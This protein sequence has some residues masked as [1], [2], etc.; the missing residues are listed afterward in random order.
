MYGNK[1]IYIYKARK[2]V[3]EQELEKEAAL[4]SHLM[5]LNSI[6]CR[7]SL[8]HSLF[9]ALH[10]RCPFSRLSICISV[11]LHDL[12]IT[13]THMDQ[14]TLNNTNLGFEVLTPVVK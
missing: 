11:S 2:E 5:S 9:F 14:A 8:L 6:A 1:V 12:Y 3:E 10:P 4:T 7:S 13:F